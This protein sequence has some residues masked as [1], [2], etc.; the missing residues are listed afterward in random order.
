MVVRLRHFAARTAGIERGAG[1]R[2]IRPVAPTH[3]RDRPSTLPWVPTRGA[4]LIVIAPLATSS[5]GT[6]PVR[7]RRWGILGAWTAWGLL[8][9]AEVALASR[10]GARPIPFGAA[11]RLQMPLALAWALVTPAVIRLGRAISPFDGPRWSVGVAVNLVASMVVVFVLGLGFVANERW[12]LG[13]SPGA[14]PLSRAALREFIVW[15]SSDG[16]LYWAILAIDYGIR[17]FRRLRERELR[18]SQL[19]AQ[20][21]EARLQAL[22]MQLHPHFLFNALHTISQ[23]IR[24]GR[25]TRAVAVVAGL[26]D[27]LRRM[28]DDATT[29]E[30]PLK[31]EIEFLQS[32]LDI[33]QIRFRDRLKVVVSADAETLD[34]RVPHLILQPLVENA[35][36]HGI[37]PRAAAGR[38]LIGARRIGAGLHLTI[39]DDGSGLPEE[40]GSA[41]R[42]V[43]IANTSA[44]LRQLYGDEASLEV[45]NATGGGVVARIVVPFRL[46]AAEWRG[47]GP[48]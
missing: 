29:Q 46:A 41:V 39:R 44:R 30:V 43:G 40:G 4:E 33:E 31:Q 42:G 28:L 8:W 26:G 12:V 17:H 36:R 7:F 24:A 35:I 23:L 16:L 13:A 32:Y 2:H 45:V 9:S 27:L 21:A 19:E 34:A 15:F 14:P 11:L 48:G 38:L 6:F 1:A 18:A 10:L 22:K 47:V 37:A 25:S 20:L 3:H 5:R